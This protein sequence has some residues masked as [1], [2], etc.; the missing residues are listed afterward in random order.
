M[1]NQ[2]KALKRLGEIL[3]D[4]I[5]KYYDAERSI[6]ILGADLAEKYV[7]INHPVMD[8]K[9]GQMVIENDLTRGRYDVTVTSG[10]S[11]DT[12]RNVLILVHD[13]GRRTGCLYHRTVL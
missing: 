10:K 11:Y 3:V 7:Q 9:T 1:D 4:A 8:P 5:P 13:N 2:V 12:R 6:R